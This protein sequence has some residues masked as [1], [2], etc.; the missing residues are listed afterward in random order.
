M[1]ESIIE[2]ENITVIGGGA[3]GRSGELLEG[4][5][6]RA[7][8]GAK[9]FNETWLARGRNWELMSS[10][11]INDLDAMWLAASIGKFLAENDLNLTTGGYDL[12]VMG[13]VNRSAC[14]FSKHRLQHE[15]K[16]GTDVIERVGVPLPNYFPDE[17]CTHVGSVVKAGEN[18]SDR[19]EKLVQSSDAFIVMRG[20]HGTLNELTTV[21]EEEDLRRESG[22]SD[23]LVKFS[24]RPIIIADPSGYTENLLGA[25]YGQ[26]IIKFKNSEEANFLDQI[27]I[28]PENSYVID[29]TTPLK[30]TIRLSKKGEEYITDILQI[31]S[32]GGDQGVPDT[33]VPTLRE[34]INKSDNKIKQGY[35]IMTEIAKETLAENMSAKNVVDKLILAAQAEEWDKIDEEIIPQISTSLYSKEIVNKLL[36][37]VKN[38]DSNIRDAIATGLMAAEIADEKLLGTAIKEM[39]TVAT[40]DSEKFPAGRAALFLSKYQSDNRFE[41]EINKAL[42]NFRNIAVSNSWVE[43][44]IENIPDIKALLIF[45]R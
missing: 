27:Y 28:L 11:E 1:S 12:G 4:E 20:A 43:D 16:I 23:N 36:E 18:L 17:V 6:Q 10:D 45:Q 2:H 34:I 15:G 44:L 26:A 29:R 38:E 14:I 25:I 33:G 7:R 35:K 30:A 24:P 31:Y 5:P 39:A 41:L 32:D 21:V 8:S 42:I 13:M 19:L 37:Y 3:G 40:T 22:K 9:V